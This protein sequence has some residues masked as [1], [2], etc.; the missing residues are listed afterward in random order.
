MDTT[1]III[2]SVVGAVILFG[3]IVPLVFTLILSNKIYLHHFRRDSP[4]KWTRVCSWTQ[5][6][7]QVKMYEIGLKWGEDNEKFIKN[8]HVENDGFNLFGQF[9]DFGFDNAVIIHQGRTEACKYSYFFGEPYKKAGFNVLVIDPRAHGFSDGKYNSIGKYES[10][11]LL[12]WAEYLHYLLGMKKIVIHGVCIG[13]AAGAYALT[14]QRCPDYVVGMVAEG[15]YADFYDSFKNHII[16]LKHP[17]FP[18]LQE[19]N[20]WTHFYVGFSMKYG[21]KK[22]MPK[23][24]KPL[25]MLHSNTDPYSL[26]DKAVKLFDSCP[27]KSKRFKMFPSGQ[28]SHLRAVYPEEYDEEIIRF[29]KDFI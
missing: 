4:E 12:K 28:H 11:D 15:M 5:N 19:C 18:V 10:K 7:E 16:E 2:L 27:S 6:E 1:L 8:V 29:L 26:P 22:V 23:F 25:L 3:V 13:S 9:F 14:S 20:M 24:D 21:P 17:T